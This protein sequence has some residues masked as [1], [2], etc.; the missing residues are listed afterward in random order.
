MTDERVP[1]RRRRKRD[2]ITAQVRMRNPMG[3]VE[4]ATKDHRGDWYA[5]GEPRQLVTMAIRDDHLAR[6][7]ARNQ[8]TE[9]S[10]RAGRLFQALLEAAEIVG[11]RSVDTTQTPVDCGGGVPE[12]ISDRNLRA[13]KQLA[14][15]RTKLGTEGYRICTDVLGRRMRMDAVAAARGDGSRG[16]VEYYGRRL[17]EC[18]QTLSFHFQLAG[19]SAGGSRPVRAENAG[20]L[21]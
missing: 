21:S 1:K 9:V 11:A 7:W 2:A 19:K 4:P 15:I 17:R 20:A 3:L 5:P 18:L 12:M 8:I 10:F 6:L 14:E 13:V 16:A